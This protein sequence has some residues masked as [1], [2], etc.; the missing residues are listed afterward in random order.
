MTK[1]QT[2]PGEQEQASPYVGKSFLNRPGPSL[3]T[4]FLDTKQIFSTC[5]TESTGQPSMTWTTH[6]SNSSDRNKSSDSNSNSSMC[7]RWLGRHCRHPDIE[8]TGQ[9][10]HRGRSQPACAT[11]SPP[12]GLPQG[13]G[14]NLAR[15]KKGPRGS[16]GGKTPV[17]VS[18]DS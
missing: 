12:Q 2:G 6:G 3:I 15:L 11:T 5:P 9:P 18:S 13:G 17:L 7:R 8:K 14:L 1:V 16:T 10:V 4:F